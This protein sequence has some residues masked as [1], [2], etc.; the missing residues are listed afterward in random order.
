V[1]GDLAGIVGVLADAG[2]ELIVIGGLAAQAHGSARLTQDVDIVYRRTPD[3]IARLCGALA[4]HQPYL[5]GAPA[6]L[7]FHFD[8]D[9]VERGLNFTLT[10]DIGDVDLLGDM[11]GGG[12]FEEIEPHS[13][14]LT[15]FGRSVR[16]IGL[17]ALIRAKRAAGRPKDFEAIAELEA[18][19]AERERRG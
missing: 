3:N 11:A 18:L 14:V 6:G 4:A 19:L 2:V 13:V 12:T 17:P 15:V 5:R 16:V 9:T 8:P 7:P 10:T 1:A